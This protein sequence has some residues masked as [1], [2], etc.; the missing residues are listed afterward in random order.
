ML[1][2]E[3]A[4]AR[5][6]RVPENVSTIVHRQLAALT[7]EPP[8]L[9]ASGRSGR[10]LSLDQRFQPQLLL[11]VLEDILGSRNLGRSE[12]TAWEV[13]FGYGGTLCVAAFRKYGLRLEAYTNGMPDRTLDSLLLELAELLAT[14]VKLVERHVFQDFISDQV[15]AGAVG[16]V[17]QYGRLRGMYRHFRELTEAAHNGD[18]QLTSLPSSSG[19]LWL[20]AAQT[21]GFYTT[22]AMVNAYFSYLEHLFVLMLPFSG[23]DASKEDLVSFL[24]GKLG[25][26]FKRVIPLAGNSDAQKFYDRLRSIAEEFRNTHVHGGFD[27][28]HGGLI[29][30]CAG[31]ALRADIATR[32]GGPYYELVPVDEGEFEHVC[33]IFDEFDAWIAPTRGHRWA[34]AGLTVAFDPASVATYADAADDAAFDNLLKRTSY[35]EERNANMDW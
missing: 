19:G 30:L 5:W 10:R 8:A 12:K 29:V 23:F 16:V 22:V 3:G 26:K 9:G 35:M 27:K 33:A 24:K 14:A 31:G 15:K 11:L 13:H 6:P 28:R 2:S 32:R 18:G 20:L 4:R 21:E 17:N 7:A 34:V 1:D 25:D